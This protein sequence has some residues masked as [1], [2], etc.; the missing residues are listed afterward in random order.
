LRSGALSLRVS[1]WRASS[2][3]QPRETAYRNEHTTQHHSALALAFSGTAKL[4][5]EVAG[6][7]IRTWH[8]MPTDRMGPPP[9]TSPPMRM[10]ASWSGKQSYRIQ[11]CSTKMC[12]NGELPSDHNRPTGTTRHR[13]TRKARLAVHHRSACSGVKALR[14][15]STLGG[16]PPSF[17]TVSVP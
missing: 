2:Y 6:S 11:V 8:L 7:R 4:R 13:G 17:A 10:T 1:H 16:K 14:N 9:G 5:S 3:V 15:T 12:P